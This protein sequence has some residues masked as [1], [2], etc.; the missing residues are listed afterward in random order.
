MTNAMIWTFGILAFIVLNNLA[1]RFGHRG[2]WWARHAGVSQDG[3]RL[4]HLSDDLGEIK[5]RLASI[6]E[7]L[8][9]VE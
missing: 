5:T 8:R 2:P 1:S 9:S 4:K 7:I 6:E 3:A